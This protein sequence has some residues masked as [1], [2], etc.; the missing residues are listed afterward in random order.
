M[1]PAR[2][3]SQQRHTVQI[4][5]LPHPGIERLDHF[6]RNVV[7][8]P[9]GYRRIT[10]SAVHG[11]DVADVYRDRLEAKIFHR[12][13]RK[14]EMDLLE[15]CVGRDDVH[16]PVRQPVNSRVVI[17]PRNDVLVLG[18][19]ND[20]PHAVD[21]AELTELADRGKLWIVL[22]VDISHGY[23][24]ALTLATERAVGR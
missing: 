23:S 1:G 13:E 21:Q 11:R 19:A 3:P 9:E 6:H 2:I 20:R 10:G 24:V 18:I 15:Q 4:H 5:G 16:T 17:D 22:L 14:V 7:W 12:G 8:N